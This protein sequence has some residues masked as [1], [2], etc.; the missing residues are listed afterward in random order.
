MHV[1]RRTAGTFAET[2]TGAVAEAGFYSRS[3]RLSGDDLAI[4]KGSS[5]VSG[6]TEAGEVQ[7]FHRQTD[8]SWLLDKV[9]HAPD[10][11]LQQHFGTQVTLLGNRVVA[12]SVPAG[13]S[14]GVVYD[15]EKRSLL[16]LLF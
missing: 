3:I 11:T 13:A 6:L 2:W 9:L 10:V 12:A 8:D 15:F 5:T 14:P 16:S 1:Y 4:G 7:L